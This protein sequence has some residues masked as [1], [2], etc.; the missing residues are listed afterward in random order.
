MAVFSLSTTET[1]LPSNIETIPRVVL[2]LIRAA[3][4][5]HV[6]M[7]SVY[8]DC[9]MPQLLSMMVPEGRPWQEKK[10]FLLVLVLVS[11]CVIYQS[12]VH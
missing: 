3:A 4:G 10:M 1:D 6:G 9:A 7:T 8:C 5:L 12:A 2:P 11:N